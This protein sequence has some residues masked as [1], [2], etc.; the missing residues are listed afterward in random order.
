M[1]ELLNQLLV[2]AL[3]LLLPLGIAS[4]LGGLLFAVLSQ[5]IFKQILTLMVQAGRVGFLLLTLLL[6]KSWMLAHWL[7]WFGRFDF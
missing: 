5:L 3:K 2:L 7:S 4:L 6:L 1:N